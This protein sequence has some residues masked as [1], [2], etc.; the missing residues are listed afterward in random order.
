MM[1]RLGAAEARRIFLAAQGLARRRA[2]GT[3]GERQFREYLDRQGLLQLDT[4]NVLARAHYLPLFSRY[5]AYDTAELDRYLWG[6]PDG[7]SAHCFEHWGHEASVMPLDLL[8]ALH[9]R[10]AGQTPQR[11]R[12]R[13]SLERDAPG[14]VE[15]VRRAVLDAPGALAASSLEHLAPAGGGGGW[16]D[17]GTV[18]W[19]LEYLFHSGGLAATRGRH[20]ARLYDDPV[21]AWGREASDGALAPDQAGQALFDRSLPA[22]GIGTPKDFVDH[23]RLPVNQS[24]RLADS[25]VERGLAAWVEV[26]GWGE[27]ALLASGAADPGRAT[28]AALL[29]PFDPV[30][31]Y[32]DRLLRMFGMHYRIEIYTPEAKREYGYYTLPFLLGDQV[33]GRLDLK[34]DR[35]AKALLVQAAWREEAPVAGARRRSDDDVAAALADEL[36]LAAG[37]LRLEGIAVG[38]RGT[39]APALAVALRE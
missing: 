21:R 22:S 20:F 11:V 5:G 29:N 13:E 25:A 26:D 4:V 34:A 8:P 28:G 2:A 10:M 36:R 7:H 39:L 24:A 32:R 18:K 15:E 12:F 19:A 16:W 9:A 17:H 23:F 31:R 33:V 14:L 30:C 1:P 35:K 37:W 3:V 38:P 6:D 27:L